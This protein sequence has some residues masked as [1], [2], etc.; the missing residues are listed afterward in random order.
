MFCAVGVIRMGCVFVRV[1]IVMFI[2]GV[3]RFGLTLRCWRVA[4]SSLERLALCVIMFVMRVFMIVSV[5]M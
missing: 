2:T 1:R 5:V 4:R 3:R